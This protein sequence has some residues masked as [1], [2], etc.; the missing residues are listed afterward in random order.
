LEAVRLLLV[1]STVGEGRSAEAASMFSCELG[2]SRASLL[3]TG[4]DNFTLVAG[5]NAGAGFVL[6]RELF[7]VVS[8]RHEDL[9]A[10]SGEGLEAVAGEDAGAG[11]DF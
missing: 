11:E 10:G 6:G 4:V 5:L 3:G 7:L 8:F 1:G 2:G 9:E